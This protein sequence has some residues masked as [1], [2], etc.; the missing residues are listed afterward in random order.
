MTSLPHPDIAA[1]LDGLEASDRPVESA[2]VLPPEAYRS[3]AFH[4]FEMA[5]VYMRSWLCVGRAQQIP[6]TGDYMALTLA[7]E[8]ILVVRGNDG[9]V[10]AMTAVC[11][12]R[13]HVLKEECAGNTR[14]FTCPYH[15]WTY[16][17]AGEFVGAPHWPTRRTSPTSG[18]KERCRSSR[19]SS[20]TASSS[21]ISTRRRGRSHRP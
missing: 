5:A 8:P 12:H 13:G 15:R 3:A 18:A 7:A 2:R 21:S 17:L 19:S 16:G 1:V 10:R 4:E 9:E 6:N 14:A 11:R 20:G